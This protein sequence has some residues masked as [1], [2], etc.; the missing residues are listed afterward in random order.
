M[1]CLEPGGDVRFGLGN[2]SAQR[3]RI[4]KS[5]DLI[6][7]TRRVITQA[8]VGKTIGI[9]TSIEVKRPG[10]KYTGTPTE[11]AQKAWLDAVETWGGLATFAT[12]PED[13]WP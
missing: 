9:F 12:G 7:I 3:N 1:R 2:D 10:W 11:V 5:S 13:V 4:F 6:G 8:D